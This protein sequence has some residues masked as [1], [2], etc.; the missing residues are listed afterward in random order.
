MSSWN[1]SPSETHFCSDPF[2]PVLVPV[3]IKNLEIM[4]SWTL[5]PSE[6]HFCWDTFV[7][8]WYFREWV[9]VPVEQNKSGDHVFLNSKSIREALLLRS[10]CTSI[11][12]SRNK[13]IWRS[14][15][16]EFCLNSK[17]FRE[18]LLLRYCGT[19]LVLQRMSISTGRTQQI[20]RLY[21]L[22]FV[23]CDI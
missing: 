8:A 21:V 23:V 2:V 11:S 13:K 16:L 10:I 20:L 1:S 19:R 7:P 3:E 9:L 15:V 5:S 22:E 4:C 17:S 12:T 6:N 18:S 14:C